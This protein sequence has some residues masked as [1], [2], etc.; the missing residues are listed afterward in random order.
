[1]SRLLAIQ[2][3]LDDPV[4]KPNEAK[5]VRWLSHDAAVA[6]LLHTLPLLIASLDREA[7][8]H[9]E[10]TAGGLLCF[11]KTHFSLPLCM[12]CTR[13]SPMFVGSLASF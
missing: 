5:D 6:T 3:L 9:G 8:E 1:M 11:A 13:Y 4:I 7:S 12:F 10:L 2:A